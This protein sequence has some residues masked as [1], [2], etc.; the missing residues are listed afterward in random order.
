MQVCNKEV[1]CF[2]WR[3]VATFT[4]DRTLLA[5]DIDISSNEL[6]MA[7]NKIYK[8]MKYIGKLN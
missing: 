7:T 5:R 3:T 1:F 6:R 2:L 4:D 8:C